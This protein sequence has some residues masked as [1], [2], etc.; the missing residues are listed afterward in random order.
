MGTDWNFESPAPSRS[1]VFWRTLGIALGILVLACFLADYCWNAYVRFATGSQLRRLA[2]G[3]AGARGEALEG[4]AY[5][6]VSAAPAVAD[7]L[8]SRDPSLRRAALV[9]SRPVLGVCL[10]KLSEMNCAFGIVL[11]RDAAVSAF[12]RLKSA[13]RDA[14][15][16]PDETIRIDAVRV[17]SGA[18]DPEKVHLDPTMKEV[19]EVLRNALKSERD[20]SARKELIELLTQFRPSMYLEGASALVAATDD[21]DEG[22]RQAAIHTLTDSLGDSTCPK[23]EE[24]REKL[25]EVAPLILRDAKGRK[26]T[27]ALLALGILGEDG[28]VGELVD[29]LHDP[30]Q[31]FRRSAAVALGRLGYFAFVLRSVNDDG[32]GAELRKAVPPLV[33]ALEDPVDDVRRHASDAL[34]SMGVEALGAIPAIEKAAEKETVPF[35]R[36]SMTESGRSIRLAAEIDRLRAS[37]ATT[38]AVEPR[39]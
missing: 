37:S 27:P 25:R 19:G 31:S 30:D 1:G 15:R 4:I 35:L 21:P 23:D 10:S 36:W 33:A 8:K 34:A 39:R 26:R 28:A 13:L 32:L 16:D 2:T 38:K 20:P 7:A 22:V 3:D 5:F 14:L 9:A 11:G 24:V 6:G 18:M 12:E 29:L 17:L